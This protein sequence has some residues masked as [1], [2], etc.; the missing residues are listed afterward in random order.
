VGDGREGH[1]GGNRE[2]AAGGTSTS[3]GVARLIVGFTGSRRGMTRHQREV[4]EQWLHENRPDEAHHGLCVGSDEEFHWL[5]RD[6]GGVW[7]EGHPPTDPKLRAWL[8]CDVLHPEKPYLDR[9]W[10]IVRAGGLLLA[11]P[12]NRPWKGGTWRTI[13]FAH[14]VKRRTIL[15]RPDGV[16]LDSDHPIVTP[17]FWVDPSLP[18]AE[19]RAAVRAQTGLDWRLIPDALLDRWRTHAAELQERYGGGSVAQLPME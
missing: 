7:I 11:T 2:A 13:G 5:C 18:P 10:D 4:V 3:A 15:V 17:P 14:Q 16:V 6:L 1:A 12:R 8:E 19:Y 9:D